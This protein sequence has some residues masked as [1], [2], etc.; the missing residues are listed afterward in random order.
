MTEKAET[1][2][3]FEPKKLTHFNNRCSLLTPRE[4]PAP[5]GVGSSSELIKPL[6]YE[7]LSVL[8]VVPQN[9]FY[10]S[11]AIFA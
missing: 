3:L 7:A 4:H 9:V 5:N 6:N 11:Q 1:V 10:V 8:G 2:Q